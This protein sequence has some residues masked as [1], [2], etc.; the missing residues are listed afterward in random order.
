LEKKD[1]KRGNGVHHAFK[2]QERVENREKGQKMEALAGPAKESTSMEA[3]VVIRGACFPEKIQ[4]KGGGGGKNEASR[5]IKKKKM[6]GSAG[7]GH[8][9][10]GSRK[11]RPVE[12]KQTQSRH[13]FNSQNPKREKKK[14]FWQ[15]KTISSTE[16]CRKSG[17]HWGE[18][19]T[20][21]PL[22][23]ETRLRDVGLV[24]KSSRMIKA[25]RRETALRYWVG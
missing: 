13:A 24:E 15:T 10:G 25:V 18:W 20:S 16:G 21:S 12:K 4:E 1:R 8:S 3:V 7:K 14:T 22:T 23:G 11:T 5:R 6:R 19:A 17:C 9:A 2:R